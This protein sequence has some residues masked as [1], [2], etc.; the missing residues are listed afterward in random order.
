MS[1]SE[2]LAGSIVALSL[3]AFLLSVL[4][5]ARFHRD[6]QRCHLYWGAGLAL[7][8]VT[9]VEEAALFVGV[10]S[11][12]LVQSYLVLVGVLVGILSLGS[13]ELS[14]SGRWKPVWFGYIALTSA[15]LAAVGFLSPASPSIVV[16]GVVSGIPSTPVVIA[17]SLVTYPAAGLLI[18]SSLYGAL[19]GKRLQLLYITFGT[20]IIA[21]A[22]SLYLVAFPVSLYYAEFVGVALLF[23]GFVKIPALSAPRLARPVTS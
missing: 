4:V 13:A 20:V 22:G 12:L 1:A 18:A 3:V 2:T 11:Q 23:L 7:V 16:A 5:L 19:R 21:A 15:A 9:L 14:L 10:W 6:R 17:S 8:F